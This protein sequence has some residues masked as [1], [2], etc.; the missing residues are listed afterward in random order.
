MVLWSVA[1]GGSMFQLVQYARVSSFIV[2]VEISLIMLFTH[3]PPIL[4]PIL[5]ALSH[6]NTIRFHNT[7]QGSKGRR[8]RVDY[9][10]C[11]VQAC[12]VD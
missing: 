8:A 9:Q 4:P 1:V 11:G 5:Y 6:T 7:G 12:M 3:I 10:S 2:M